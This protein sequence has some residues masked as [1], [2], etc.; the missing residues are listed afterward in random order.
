MSGNVKLTTATEKLVIKK[1]GIP[2]DQL[3]ET[4]RAP[5]KTDEI[6]FQGLTVRIHTKLSN[7]MQPLCTLLVL[8]TVKGDERAVSTAFRAYPELTQNLQELRPLKVLQLLTDSFGLL[9]RVGNKVGRLILQERFDA[10]TD[11]NVNLVQGLDAPRG[12]FSQHI[13]FKIEEGPPREVQCALAFV[14]DDELYGAWLDGVTR[15]SK[16]ASPWT[17][18]GKKSGASPKDMKWKMFEKLVAAIHRVEQKGAEVKWNDKINGRQFD[19][20]VRFKGGIY[21]YLTVVECRE[22]EKP[23]KVAEV[24]EFVTKSSDAKANKAIMVSSSGFQKGC[25]DVAEKHGVELF[26]VQEVRDLPDDLLESSFLTPA[27][28]IH[29]FSLDCGDENIDLPERRNILPF[30][31]KDTLIEY[32]SQ[33][34][35]IERIID[36]LY[37]QL[38]GSA[39]REIKS[40]RLELPAGSMV[41]L[42]DIKSGNTLETIRLSIRAVSFKYQLTI[43]RYYAGE[44][45]DPHIAHTRYEFRNAVSGEST[46]YRPRELEVGFDT[47]FKPGIFYVDVHTEF[48]Y[49][50]HRVEGDLITLTM[51]EGYQHGR[52]LQVTFSVLREN[53]KSYVEVTDKVE[54]ERLKAMLRT[55]RDKGGLNS[56]GEEILDC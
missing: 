3:F 39:T 51:L 5:D 44:G 22:K 25:F 31:I 1:Y 53:A 55:L 7:S 12:A 56:G 36:D 14:I 16:K 26:T 8:E 38:A 29:S 45:L 13:H 49:F 37:F 48:Y 50:C 33:R 24:D 40:F 27:L 19:V 20:T 17:R 9:M 30:L 54:V 23:L 18:Q 34:F 2:T 11:K 32:G 4:L 43:A 15:Q 52:H 28:N 41:E 35:S 21:N 6:N 42:P 46:V 10:P 47:A